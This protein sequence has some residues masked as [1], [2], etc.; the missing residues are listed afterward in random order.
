MISNGPEADADALDDDALLQAYLGTD[1]DHLAVGQA[2]PAILTDW[3]APRTRDVGLTLDNDT[4]SWFQ[5]RHP[6][7]R[8][9]MRFVLRAWTI[10]RSKPETFSRT[11][12]SRPGNGQTAG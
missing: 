10:A 4:V 7:W 3:P 8:S 1:A 5:T 11:R 2:S 9:E 6:D 12:D